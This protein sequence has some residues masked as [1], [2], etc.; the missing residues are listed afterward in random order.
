M[1]NEGRWGHNDVIM[2]ILSIKSK[3]RLLPAVVGKQG[4]H[5]IGTT[6]ASCIVK[7]VVKVTKQLI[8][9][10]K[11]SVTNV[12][13]QTGGFHGSDNIYLRKAKYYLYKTTD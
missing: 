1:N 3:L 7:R 8:R 9:T 12:A 5:Q 13:K 4:S 10:G 2:T 11:V 6:P